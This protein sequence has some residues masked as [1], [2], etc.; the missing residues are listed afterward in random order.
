MTWI[1]AWDMAS[2]GSVT[3]NLESMSVSRLHTPLIWKKLESRVWVI[4]SN[5]PGNDFETNLISTLLTLPMNSK[6]V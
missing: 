4:D 2:M 3:A 5:L 6:L 1:M